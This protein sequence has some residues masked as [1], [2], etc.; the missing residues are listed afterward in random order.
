MA[1]TTSA[2]N[3]AVTERDRVIDI[4]VD[5]L[6]RE[7]YEAVQLREVARRART[8]LATIYKR[9]PTQFEYGSRDGFQKV[10]PPSAWKHKLFESFGT[11]GEMRQVSLVLQP[12]NLCEVVIP[13]S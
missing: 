6:E 5:I 13:T 9:Y 11:V 10:D 12:A 1:V 8:S 7:G 2:G 4:V 3:V